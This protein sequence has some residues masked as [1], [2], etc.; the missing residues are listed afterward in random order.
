MKVTALALLAGTAASATVLSLP[1]QQNND[2]PT[3]SN[4]LSI[5]EPIES[6]RPLSSEA[7]SHTVFTIPTGPGPVVTTTDHASLPIGTVPTPSE[8]TSA[9]ASKSMTRSHSGQSFSSIPTPTASGASG[10]G[11]KTGATN[12]GTAAPS[13]TSGAAGAPRATAGAVAGLVGLVAALL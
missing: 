12:S 4:R 13:S 3:S 11:S 7:F 9:P 1:V 10:T 2:A 5:I 6:F 8:E